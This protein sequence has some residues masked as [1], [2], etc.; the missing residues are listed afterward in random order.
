MN[1]PKETERKLQTIVEKHQLTKKLSVSAVQDWVWNEDGNS[2]IDASNRYQLKWMKFFANVEGDE[3]NRVLQVFTD[4]WNYFPHKPLDGKSPDELF[5]AQL[6]NLP[7]KNPSPSRKPKVIVGGR[8]MSW[9]QYTAMITEMERLQ[10]PFKQWVENEV[11][12]E[13]EMVLKAKFSPKTMDKHMT[14]ADIFFER[15]RYVGFLSFE[16]IRDGFIQKEFPKWWQTH[17]M[18]TSLSEK[19][20]V[21]SLRSLLSFIEGR[22]GIKIK[23]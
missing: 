23:Q 14:V 3:F 16:G 19:Q 20:I 13:Y 2:A 1:K 6:K 5:R 22:Y 18:F 11:L 15:A 21:S 9:N 7:A 8:E 12:P 4:A 10:I 17:V